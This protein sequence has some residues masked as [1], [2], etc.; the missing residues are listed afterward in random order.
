ME[1]PDFLIRQLGHQGPVL[2]CWDEATLTAEKLAVEGLT[3]YRLI[4]P[5]DVPESESE[6]IHPKVKILKSS[7]MALPFTEH[8]QAVILVHYLE[9]VPSL[10]WHALPE[11]LWRALRP[12]GLVVV[13][14]PRGRSK[15]GDLKEID[16]LMRESRFVRDFIA[17]PGFDFPGI[18][19]IIGGIWRKPPPLTEEEESIKVVNRY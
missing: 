4:N 1:F 15:E 5:N 10:F 13:A 12:E 17:G 2:V 11:M 9:R 8:L 19:E 16:R 6:N 3:V 7:W 18:F 14:E